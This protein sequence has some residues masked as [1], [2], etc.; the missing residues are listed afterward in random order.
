MKARA[1]AGEREQLPLVLIAI[2]RLSEAIAGETRELS[3]PGPVDYRTHSQ[4]KS[5]GL[6][7]LS[8][9]EATL[10]SARDHPKLR[11]A[12]AGL[13]QNLDTNQRLLHARLSAARTVAE[14]VSR[15]I[16]DGQSDGT[17]SD[18]VWRENRK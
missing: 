13:I 16:L 14:V 2:D 17:Y 15:A 18:Q 4:R 8:R 3:G 10:S 11:T 5:Q 7:E 6:L 1:E 12:L 9:L